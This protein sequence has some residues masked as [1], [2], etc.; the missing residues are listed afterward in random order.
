MST[1]KV[2]RLQSRDSHHFIKQHSETVPTINSHE[3]LIKIRAISLNYRDIAVVNGIYPFP[4]K[5][6]VIPCSD[7]AGE[8]IKVG[9]DVGDLKVGDHVVAVFD[10]SNLYGPQKDWNHGHGGPIDGFLCEFTALPAT[11]VVRIPE[12]A[13][14]TFPQMA[15]L[16]CTGTTA[17][18]ALYGNVPLRPG[19]TVLFQGM[20]CYVL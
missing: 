19:Q 4:V 8:I 5:D 12:A 13:A 11:S 14:L 2:F 9:S 7:A 15:A 20:L 1:Q 17:W 16:V 10:G 6:Q 18:N 3:V